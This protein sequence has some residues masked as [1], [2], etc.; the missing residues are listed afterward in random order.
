MS[1]ILSNWWRSYQ[2]SRALRR[3]EQKR[4]HKLWGAI[5]LSG[6]KLNWL[7]KLYKSNREATKKHRE[8]QGGLSSLR[9]QIAESSQQ[10]RELE[11]LRTESS[12]QIQQLEL[13][14]AT[15][16]QQAQHSELLLQESSQQI[17]QLELAL[18]AATIK[19][20]VPR[21]SL[22]PQKSNLISPNPEFI[23]FISKTFKFVEHDEH[24]LQV[25]GL[26]HQVFDKFEASL[27][28]FIQD[29]FTHLSKE[30]IFKINLREALVDI[31]ALKSSL[32]LDP[33]YDLDL[34]PHLYFI[35][36]F[37]EGVYS[38]YLAWFLIYKSGLLPARNNILDIAAGSSSVE[39]GLEL[40]LESGSNYF[41]SMPI[42]RLF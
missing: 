31:K 29:D 39:S 27:A 12:Q 32:G 24:F 30:A 40:F 8:T 9:L 16:S 17:Q 18:K 22:V 6:A 3:G 13:A 11:I 42:H 36:Y 7:E 21:K 19:S 5:E 33:S 15:A 28:K 37:L 25:T 38:S 26:D 23:D 34:S 4:V 20:P 2:F 14:I 10:V 41:N 1:N 35:T